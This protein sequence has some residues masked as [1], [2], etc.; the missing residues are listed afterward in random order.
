M[1]VEINK[2]LVQMLVIMWTFSL[3]PPNIV[4]VDLAEVKSRFPPRRFSLWS[5]TALW[6]PKVKNDPNAEIN[7][8]VLHETWNPR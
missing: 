8:N 1:N 4:G 2:I 6:C 5:I 3:R 7:K